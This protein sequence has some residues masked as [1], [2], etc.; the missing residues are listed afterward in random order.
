MYCES[1]TW[2]MI[3]PNERTSG[4]GRKLY[5][6]S[7][8]CSAERTT[9]PLEICQMLLAA[10]TETFAAGADCCCW[11]KRGLA[12]AARINAVRRMTAPGKNY[13]GPNLDCGPQSFEMRDANGPTAKFQKNFTDETNSTDELV[14]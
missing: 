11:A 5:S 6:D 13:G 4:V 9:K 8:I 14:V 10:F 2:P 1:A 3:W 12:T 7:G